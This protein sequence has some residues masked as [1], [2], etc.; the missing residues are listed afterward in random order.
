MHFSSSITTG[1]VALLPVIPGC[2]GSSSFWVSF[3]KYYL[4]Y[5][6]TY[7]GGQS[8]A[9]VT[10]PHGNHQDV[11]SNPATA[12]NEKKR[13]MGRPLHR[14][15]PNSVAGSQWKTGDVKPN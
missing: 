12:K 7:L 1:P 10:C 3:L 15:C 2:G 14:R 9:A 8:G 5:L 13:T 4:L 6:F 11:G